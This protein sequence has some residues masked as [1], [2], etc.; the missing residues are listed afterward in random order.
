MVFFIV[1]KL[2]NTEQIEIND[3]TPCS[4]SVSHVAREA[5]LIRSPFPK[6]GEIFS[7]RLCTMLQLMRVNTSERRNV[8]CNFS[9]YIYSQAQ[10][11]RE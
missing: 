4:G 2:E 5:C 8:L 11:T 3:C 1:A 10:V 7:F 6:Y 9:V